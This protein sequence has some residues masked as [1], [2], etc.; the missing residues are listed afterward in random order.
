MSGPAPGNPAVTS[1][2]NRSLNPSEVSLETGTNSTPRIGVVSAPAAMSPTVPPVRLASNVTCRDMSATAGQVIAHM[3]EPTG[4]DVEPGFLFISRTESFGQRL[5]VLELAARAATRN[6]PVS[7]SWLSRKSPAVLNHDSRHAH[8]HPA[9]L[10]D[11]SSAMPDNTLALV[12][13]AAGGLGTRVHGWARFIP[14][15]FY[16]VGGRPGLMR[17]LEEIA[18]LGPARAVIVYHPYYE[19]FA[20]LEPTRCSALATAPATPARP[21]WRPRPP[22]R[23]GWT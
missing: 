20:R 21:E 19:Q 14:K 3:Q 18:D 6:L 10:P 4:L 9:N 5:A 13:I 12:V 15:E 22:S 2:A 7:V 23:P 17:L 1:S 11:R 16:P 8:L